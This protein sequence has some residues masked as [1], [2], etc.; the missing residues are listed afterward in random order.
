MC[1]ILLLP[2]VGQRGDPGNLDAI[3]FEWNPFQTSQNHSFASTALHD[4]HRSTAKKHS[5]LTAMVWDG[6]ICYM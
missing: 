3:C 1:S 2:T 5:C 4:N 6:S